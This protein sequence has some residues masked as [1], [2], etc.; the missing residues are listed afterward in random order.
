MVEVILRQG[1]GQRNLPPI[2]SEDQPRSCLEGAGD[3]VGKRDSR[4]SK[5]LAVGD[6]DVQTTLQMRSRNDS[7]LGTRGTTLVSL[8]V[9]KYTSPFISPSSPGP[10]TVR[11]GLGFSKAPVEERIKR[12][13]REPGWVPTFFAV[14]T[15]L[16]DCA[17]VIEEAE[18][19][20]YARCANE[21]GVALLSSDERG[22]IGKLRLNTGTRKYVCMAIRGFERSVQR[23]V[24]QKTL[25]VVQNTRNRCITQLE[26]N[27]YIST[28]QSVGFTAHVFEIVG[29]NTG[30]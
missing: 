28:T 16:F 3:L 2:G 29:W 19:R 14:A 23:R 21:G 8:T 6:L 17:A 22:A 15:T 27:G 9:P 5:I 24:T 4:S 10:V 1:R 25:L 18:L 7:V 30:R 12:E 11:V 20:L 13:R 26:K